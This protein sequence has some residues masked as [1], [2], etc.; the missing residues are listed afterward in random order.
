MGLV[1]DQ[2]R[3]S[4]YEDALLDTLISYSKDENIKSSADALLFVHS[5][6]WKWIFKD[7]KAVA[8]GL[9]E[10]LS[11]KLSLFLAGVVLPEDSPIV[12]LLKKSG[13]TKER[14]MPIALLTYNNGTPRIT[15]RV[16]CVGAKDQ[17]AVT[18]LANLFRLGSLMLGIK[19]EEVRVHQDASLGS[20][21]HLTQAQNKMID[22]LVAAIQ[23]SRGLFAGETHKFKNGCEANLIEA[24]ALLRVL[25]TKSNFMR[26]KPQKKV[27]SGPRPPALNP[28]VSNDLRDLIYDKLGFKTNSVLS[29]GGLFLKWLINTACSVHC[30]SFPGSFMFAAKVRNNTKS[31]EGL[32]VRMG[33]VPLAP[34]GTSLVSVI[35]TKTKSDEKDPKPVLIEANEKEFPE[36]ISFREFRTALVLALPKLSIGDERPMKAQLNT[37]DINIQ[38]RETLV[39]YKN[40]RIA[41]CVDEL[42]RAYGCKLAL[43]IKDSKAT[44]RHF[45]SQRNALI[46]SSA[47]L[48]LFDARGNEYKTERDVPEQ[49]LRYVAKT[50]NYKLKEKRPA[51]EK[52]ESETNKRP[53]HEIA[54][55]SKEDIPLDD[56][57]EEEA[58]N[59]LHLFRLKEGKLPEGDY[60]SFSWDE[61]DELCAAYQAGESFEALVT[62]VY[63]EF[64]DPAP[65]RRDE[66]MS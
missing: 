23:S 44:A 19:K 25:Q 20:A 55:H 16:P 30:K 36:G 61:N 58:R 34:S 15:I 6:L 4:V 22:S 41:Q 43:K 7:T 37:D 3:D 38:T 47:N 56:D 24:M 35:M 60:S 54:Y 48:P 52:R 27:I 26:Q 17:S 53:K 42:A 21:C 10:R 31:T 13:V 62:R 49:M 45:V 46:N 9:A 33:Y 50:F 28:V 1:A 64:F 63:P 66:E 11:L 51:E 39:V 32:L 59:R 14:T 8:S 12:A 57:E 29:Y 40:P 2:I 65:Q 18:N 5:K